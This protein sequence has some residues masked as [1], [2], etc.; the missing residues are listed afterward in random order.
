LKYGGYY[1]HIF[2]YKITGDQFLI[3]LQIKLK[4]SQI[5]GVKIITEQ[6]CLP[7]AHIN[8]IKMILALH[9]VKTAL[10]KSLPQMNHE[11]PR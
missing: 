4:I 1:Q 2:L 11:L 7:A 10:L 5:D 8:Q 9:E 6:F 3:S